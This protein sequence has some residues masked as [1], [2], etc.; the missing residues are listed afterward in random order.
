MTNDITPSTTSPWQTMEEWEDHLREQ[1]PDNA[2][3]PEGLLRVLRRFRPFQFDAVVSTGP[4]WHELIIKLND[5]LA[6][7][8]PGYVVD[9]VKEKFGGLRYYATLSSG[10]TE[11]RVDLL[12][13]GGPP[14]CWVRRAP[15]HDD[16]WGLIAKAEDQSFEICEACGAPG[17]PA[18]TKSGWHL[19]SCRACAQ[20]RDLITE[21]D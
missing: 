9:Q 3:D 6:A 10:E 17:A 2:A 19:T 5:D 20:A 12:I 15:G 16:F 1:V 8:D 7:L 21:E 14:Q 11:E 18:M 4:G 13:P